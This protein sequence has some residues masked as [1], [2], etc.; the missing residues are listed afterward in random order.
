MR[1]IAT[2]IRLLATIASG[3]LVS[4]GANAQDNYP[5]RPIHIIVPYPAGGIVDIVARAVT[6]QVGRDWKQTVVVEARPGGNSNIGTSAVARSEP[7]GYTWVVT[8]P[9]LLVNPDLYKD[10]GWNAA[11]DFRCVGLAVWNQ[12]VALVHPSMPVMSIGEFVELARKQ[13]GEFNFGNPGTGSSIDL[14]AQKLFQAAGI[15]LTNV[16]YKGQPQALIDLMTNLMH[17]EIVS[18]ELALPHIKAGSVKPLA[19]FTDKRV[20]DLP[21]VPTIAEAGFA[22]AAYVPWYGIYVPAATPAPLLAKINAAINKALQNPDV[23]RQLSL[24]NIPG[25]PMSLDELAALMKADQQKL[26]TV[27]KTSGMALQ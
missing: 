5:S 11:R 2:A 16:G 1:G 13:P 20:P 9:A 18:L 12:S 22:E 27:I 26:T 19:V 15:K 25:K 21:D 14:S 4:A 7:D 3:L 10:A 23:Q 17:F 24:A 8:G 6:E